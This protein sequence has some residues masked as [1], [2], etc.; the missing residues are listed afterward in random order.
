MHTN[1]LEK[2]SMFKYK[3]LEK[4]F[5]VQ[6]MTK[7][8]GQKEK[9]NYEAKMAVSKGNFCNFRQW[10]EM[11]WLIRNKSLV[12]QEWQT[13]NAASFLMQTQM[14]NTLCF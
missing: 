10:S 14:W 7:L 8:M 4:S 2:R 12:F 3:T 11:F 13:T 5:C 1:T 6:K 9:G